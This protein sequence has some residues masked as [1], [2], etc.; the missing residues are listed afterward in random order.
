MLIVYKKFGIPIRKH[1]FEHQPRPG[2]LDYLLPS[3]YM[4]CHGDKRPPLYQQISRHTLINDLSPS[5]EEIFSGFQSRTRSYIRKAQREAFFTLDKQVSLNE[6]MPFCDRFSRDKG[7]SY[8]ELQGMDKLAASDFAIFAMRREGKIV[9]AHLYLCSQE[10]K[11]A[12]LLISASDPE[13]SQQDEINTHMGR[14]NRELHWLAIQHF[15]QQGFK[16]YD[17]GGYA[18]DTEDPSLQGI[19]RFKRHFNGELKPI[20]NYYSPSYLLLQKLRQKLQRDSKQ[21]SCC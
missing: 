10:E 11:T 16:Y 3:S 20:Y 15:K 18:L 5:E 13:L 7:L 6:F 21:L 8:F 17:W 9:F 14:A 2:L 1:Y 4:D 12:S 19:N